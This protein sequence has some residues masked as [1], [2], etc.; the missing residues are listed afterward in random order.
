MTKRVKIK[1]YKM[2]VKPVV[3]YDSETWP[4]AEMGIKGLNTW[5]R[6]MLRR[7]EGPEVEQGIWRIRTNQELRELCKDLDTVADIKKAGQEMTGHL[8]RLDR[9]RT[10]NT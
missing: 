4:V 8:V 3:V 5:E 7:I 2:T 10:E 9:E 6:K 1:I